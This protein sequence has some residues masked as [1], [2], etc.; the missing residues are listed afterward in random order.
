LK[1]NVL[2][3][4]NENDATVI[5]EIVFGDNDQLSASVCHF[6][7]C[8]LLVMLSDIDGYYDKN[9]TQYNDAKMIKYI[10]NITDKDIS[11]TPNPTHKFATGGI[12]TKLISAKFLLERNKEMFLVNGLDL[13]DAKSYLLD[14]IY[15]KGTFFTNSSVN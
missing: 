8:D 3:I 7:D 12:V 14:N 13:T 1:N 2:P 6:F 10:N 4:I 11:S 9:P 15:T 5:K